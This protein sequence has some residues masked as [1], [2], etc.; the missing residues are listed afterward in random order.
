MHPLSKIHDESINTFRPQRYARRNSQHAYQTYGK[1][2]KMEPIS[3]EILQSK[4]AT[5]TLATTKTTRS[6]LLIS[7]LV[8]IALVNSQLEIV[9]M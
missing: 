2:D 7:L 5:T 3:E 6:C 8:G 4:T 1:V 9:S